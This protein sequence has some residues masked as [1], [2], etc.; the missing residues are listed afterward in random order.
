MSGE[1]QHT[2]SKTGCTEPAAGVCKGCNCAMYCSEV[3]MQED[4]AA[5]KNACNLLVQ[6]HAGASMWAIEAEV[7]EL[8]E[9]GQ[10]QWVPMQMEHHGKHSVADNVPLAESIGARA[11]F[12]GDLST[13]RGTQRLPSGAMH[14]G[15][16]ASIFVKTA[17]FQTEINVS[18]PGRS[19]Y[20]IFKRNDGS[21]NVY[22]TADDIRRNGK[23]RPVP[24][25][26]LMAVGLGT[27]NQ[28]VLVFGQ[29]S[30]P[31]TAPGSTGMRV[32]EALRRFA[33]R[34]RKVRIRTF[35]RASQMAVSVT[36]E[37][38]VSAARQSI[39]DDSIFY[40]VTY[41]EIYVPGLYTKGEE[42]KSLSWD[43][44]FAKELAAD[45]TSA[46]ATEAAIERSIAFLA[47]VSVSDI[48]QAIVET[49]G[50][51]SQPEHREAEAAYIAS[52][53]GAFVAEETGENHPLV[54]GEMMED[55]EVGLVGGAMSDD[56]ADKHDS[57]GKLSFEEIGANILSRWWNRRRQ[58]RRAR[59]QRKKQMRQQQQQ[60]EQPDYSMAEIQA[61][62]DTIDAPSLRDYIVRKRNLAK[63]RSGL[64][65]QSAAKLTQRLIALVKEIKALRANG[66]AA[67]DKV[68][69]ANSIMAQLD[70]M[71][72]GSSP[73]SL[74][75]QNELKT[76][77]STTGAVKSAKRQQARAA[78]QRVKQASQAAIENASDDADEA[79]SASSATDEDVAK[80]GALVASLL[81]YQDVIRSDKKTGL[82]PAN[83]ALDENI[84]RVTSILTEHIEALSNDAKGIA[85]YD[86]VPNR[87]PLAFAAA[88]KIHKERK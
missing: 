48:A 79:S 16:G 46:V 72:G 30:V 56:L 8:S 77:T 63:Q 1:Q 24:L 45:A 9:S 51:E 81:Q 4:W 12:T 32:Y 82:T 64:K 37:Q 86:V 11:D 39:S 3:H 49:E 18:L 28:K 73:A 66:R 33:R 57:E 14:S 38:D 60:M 62:I 31:Q 23:F 69:L 59:I 53:I 41:I 61:H 19:H 25:N 15:E 35:D 26:G 87:V 78:R 71:E 21:Y 65:N 58:K 44:L 20:N 5:H 27:A 84:S 42:D 2:C 34:P 74:A 88:L 54:D 10:E 68:R 50:F 85:A 75:A 22:A 29:Y 70:T 47:G 76:L 6:Q 40:N 43:N 55:S 52:L 67:G 13:F 7:G 17:T 36:L 80:T 83:K